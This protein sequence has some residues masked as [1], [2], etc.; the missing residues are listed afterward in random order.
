MRVQALA[1]VGIESAR[2]TRIA[3]D[4]ASKKIDAIVALAMACVA[5]IEGRP[6]H[7][8]LQIYAAPGPEDLALSAPEPSP[9]VAAFLRGD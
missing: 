7:R 1:T 4:K 9:R 3:K 8:P 2:G 6:R 5:A